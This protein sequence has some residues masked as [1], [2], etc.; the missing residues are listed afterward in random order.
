MRKRTDYF[1]SQYA[2]GNALCSVT[3]FPRNPMSYSGLSSCQAYTT[4]TDIYA[5][6]TTN[7]IKL[8]E[9]TQ[10]AFISQNLII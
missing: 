5:G 9:N 10:Q 3:P 1:D 6:K 4:E 7:P 2:H 8:N